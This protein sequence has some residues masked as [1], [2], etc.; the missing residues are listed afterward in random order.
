MFPL[1]TNKAEIIRFLRFPFSSPLWCMHICLVYRAGTEIQLQ[2]FYLIWLPSEE[3]TERKREKKIWKG[4]KKMLANKPTHTQTHE[5]SLKPS[6]WIFYVAICSFIFIS[7]LGFFVVY[8]RFWS[9]CIAN[10]HNS[11]LQS[12]INKPNIIKRNQQQ[13]STTTRICR[14]SNLK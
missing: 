3:Q 12:T 10:T 5:N 4:K 14:K 9:T 11:R 6:N 8:I 1:H 7:F 2:I 13:Q